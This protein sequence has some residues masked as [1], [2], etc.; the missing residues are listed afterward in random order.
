MSTLL[1][2]WQRRLFGALPIAGASL[3]L[4]AIASQFA[5]LPFSWLDSFFLLAF[6]G[7]YLFGIAAGLLLLEDKDHALRPN[8]W[9]W[10]VQIPML[11]TS[12]F[13]FAV[14][15]GGM[16]QIYLQWAP[17]KIGFNSYLASFVSYS[18]FQPERPGLIGL[19]LFALAIALVLLRAE[20]RQQG[21]LTAALPA[22][23]P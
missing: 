3:G 11:Q 21:H 13:G 2:V 7:F 4:T 8:F 9:F 23:A 19:N 14:A 6:A 22:P 15:S 17:W 16:L 18:L 1:P 10:V 5:T 20:R 12:V